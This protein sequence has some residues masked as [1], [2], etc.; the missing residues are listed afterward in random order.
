M[1]SIV[2]G[3]TLPSDFRLGMSPTQQS[4]RL[5]ESNFCNNYS[6]PVF[7]L[8][9]LSEWE[10]SFFDKKVIDAVKDDLSCFHCTLCA[11]SLKYNKEGGDQEC[12]LSLFGKHLLPENKKNLGV[13]GGFQ[14][15]SLS[16]EVGCPCQFLS[17]F[18]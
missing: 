8:G 2:F 18:F 10:V 5:T 1:K 3:Q 4:I 9:L 13:I 6:F 7:L 14:K 12:W 16:D 15:I 11:M 17:L